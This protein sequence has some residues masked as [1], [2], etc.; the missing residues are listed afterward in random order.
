MNEQGLRIIVDPRWI[1]AVPGNDISDEVATQLGTDRRD[2]DASHL[3]DMI[4]GVLQ[5]ALDGQTWWAA[6]WAMSEG[7]ELVVV[8]AS[9]EWSGPADEPVT[10]D[11]IYDVLSLDARTADHLV[12]LTVVDSRLGAAVRH[13]QILVYS[14]GVVGDYLGFSV[15]F[16][17][18]VLSMRAFS[19]ATG[20]AGLFGPMV[21][22]MF[23]S[24]RPDPE[25]APG[26]VTMVAFVTVGEAP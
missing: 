16:A 10:A 8:R 6:A 19:T 4:A 9:L 18:G 2:P 25:S 1:V 12:E 3:A 5:S 20:W 14:D 17:G 26:T 13:R 11:D 15:P 7:D 21:E 23:L 22:E 24:L